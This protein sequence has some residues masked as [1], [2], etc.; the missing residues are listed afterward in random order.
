MSTSIILLSNYILNLKKKTDLF[1]HGYS[2]TPG[3]GI[4][5]TFCNKISPEGPSPEFHVDFNVTLC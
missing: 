2:G 1:F 5:T 4:K 3:M